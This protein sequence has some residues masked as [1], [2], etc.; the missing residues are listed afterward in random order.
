MKNVHHNSLEPKLGSSNDLF[1]LASC[2]DFFVFSEQFGKPKIDQN[3]EQIL[4]FEKLEPAND[5][6]F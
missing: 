3:V 6:Y 2:P 4:T 1:C 5:W